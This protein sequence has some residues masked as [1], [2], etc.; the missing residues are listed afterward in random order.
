MPRIF[1]WNGYIFFFFS[2]EAIPIEPCHIHVRKGANI[3]KFWILPDIALAG[4]WDISP[5]EVNIL[6]QKN[7][8]NKEYVVIDIDWFLEFII[9]IKINKFKLQNCPRYYNNYQRN[10]MFLGLYYKIKDIQ[11]IIAI[12]K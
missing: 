3:A 4:S 7:I 8:E 6:E 1:E 10:T 11:I 12:K 9:N 2:N 5:K